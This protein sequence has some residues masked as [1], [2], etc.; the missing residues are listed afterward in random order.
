MSHHLDHRIPLP[1]QDYPS[2]K[3]PIAPITNAKAHLTNTPKP[4]Y[5]FPPPL[6]D[7]PE[8]SH[9]SHIPPLSHHLRRLARSRQTTATLTKMQRIYSP[10]S[11]SSH[12]VP[13][14]T[15]PA[16][17]SSHPP[18]SSLRSSHTTITHQ[19]LIAYQHYQPSR[20][21]TTKS[22]HNAPVTLHQP[23]PP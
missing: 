12:L 6:R 18:S 7:P 8:N 11:T 17:F 22:V 10:L 16:S 21:R 3:H 19:P 13:Y 1:H 20:Y 5:P 4:P 23:L 15:T 14:S 2:S 9:L